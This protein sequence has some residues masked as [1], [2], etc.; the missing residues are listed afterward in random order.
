MLADVIFPDDLQ[1]VI[2][3]FLPL[4]E[5]ARPW[6]SCAER[7]RIGVVRRIDAAAGIAVDVPGAADLV[8]LLD[9]GIGD[10]EP[11][12]R[13]TERYG[14]DASADDQHMLLRKGFCRR[15]F[16]PG[17]MALNKSHLLAHQRRIFR[18]NVL[19][20]RRAHHLQL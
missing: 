9:D 19:A 5:I 10:A 6:I 15:L 8:V 2:E 17:G 3:Q 14:A 11:S 20:E 7:K 18:R 16:A 1:Q 13:Y 12:Q 4:R